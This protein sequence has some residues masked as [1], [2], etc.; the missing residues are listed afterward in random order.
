MADMDLD[1]TISKLGKCRIP[2]PMT[3]TQFVRDEENVVYDQDLN[4]IKACLKTGREPPYFELAGPRNKIY[5]DIISNIF[6][7]GSDCGTKVYEPC[8]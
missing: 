2:S 7:F 8:T 6:T 4:A 1:F 3:T 5:F